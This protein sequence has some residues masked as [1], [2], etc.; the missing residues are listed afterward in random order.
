MSELTWKSAITKIEPN[1]ISV[2]GYRLDELMGK[3]SY[4]DMIYLLFKGE[5]PSKNAG[6]L[7][8][9]ILVS[10]IDHGTTPPSTL[11]AIT[12]A[13]TGAPFNA[14]MAAGILAISKFHGGAIE[15]CMLILR[16]GLAYVKSDK[17]S[18]EKAAEI[19]INEYQSAKKRLSGFGHRVH[20]SD[21]RTAKLFQIA[22]KT[23]YNGESLKMAETFVQVL[24]QKTGK[25][26]PLNV[27]GTIAALL[28]E[29]DIDPALANG[30]FMIARM[31][32]LAAHVHE[33][34]TRQKPMRKI[35]PTDVEYDGP[36]E[37][38]YK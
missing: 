27:D 2:R 15:E 32:G 14:A 18:Y 4:A 23:G 21:P 8:N 25:E 24:K 16:Q 30:F 17:L 12:V 22:K 34:Y 20:T 1:K 19:I 35:H 29:L 10:S 38:N 5:L 7:I 11:S 6:E 28:C 3:V 9:A 36:D 13:S 37:R 26:L 31:P 33:E